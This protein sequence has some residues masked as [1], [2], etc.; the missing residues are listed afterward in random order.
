[1]HPSSLASGKKYP[2]PCGIW[3][4]KGGRNRGGGVESSIIMEKKM[5]ATILH[6]G[7]IG[8]MEQKMEATIS[9]ACDFT[10]ETASE[11]VPVLLG[12]KNRCCPAGLPDV[13][14]PPP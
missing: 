4:L 3:T 7:Y 8:I 2:M 5:E 10:S 12:N 1:M 6:W 14:G 9:C 13:R 11:N